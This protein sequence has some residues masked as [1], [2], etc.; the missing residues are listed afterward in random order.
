[1]AV[2]GPPAMEARWRTDDLHD[3]ASMSSRE[4]LVDA[5][6][7]GTVASLCLLAEAGVDVVWLV[8]VWMF[9]PVVKMMISHLAIHAALPVVLV[10]SIAVAVGKVFALNVS[11]LVAL[12]VYAASFAF[13]SHFLCPVVSFFLFVLLFFQFHSYFLSFFDLVDSLVVVSPSDA[14]EACHSF[15]EL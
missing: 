8:W 12:S 7:A 2:L 10:L 6:N 4:D 9:V 11:F 3:M 5:G 1:M 15:P 14:V 13:F